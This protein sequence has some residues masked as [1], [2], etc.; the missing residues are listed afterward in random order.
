MLSINAEGDDCNRLRQPAVDTPPISNESG[1]GEIVADE[2][3][4]AHEN[5]GFQIQC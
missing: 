1:A 3:D 5:S 2:D 4:N